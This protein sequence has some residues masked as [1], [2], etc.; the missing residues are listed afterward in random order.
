MSLKN[1]ILV[2][3]ALPF[4]MIGTILELTVYNSQVNI[5]GNL[6]TFDDI[7]IRNLSHVTNHTVIQNS[8]YLVYP[9]QLFIIGALCIV[10]PLLIIIL[11][12]DKKKVEYDN[13]DYDVDNE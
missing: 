7:I 1:I 6:I 12:M 13:I 4:V 5:N 2:A 11:C 8:I 10:I 3:V 9:I